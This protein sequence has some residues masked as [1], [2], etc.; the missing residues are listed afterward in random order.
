MV[1]GKLAITMIPNTCE[2]YMLARITLACSVVGQ[3][4]SIIYDTK[5]NLLLPLVAG[6]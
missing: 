6:I 2:R 1:G 3:Q 5:S 4:L